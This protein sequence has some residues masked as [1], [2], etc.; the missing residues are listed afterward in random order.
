MQ[1][2]YKAI[3]ANG[4]L[5]TDLIR[6]IADTNTIFGTGSICLASDLPGCNTGTAQHIRSGY[7]LGKVQRNPITT[8]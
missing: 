5:Y 8:R 2:S 7:Q 3:D 6:I 4:K 1:H